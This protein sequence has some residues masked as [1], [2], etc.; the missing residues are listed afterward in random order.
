M[1]VDIDRKPIALVVPEAIAALRRFFDPAEDIVDERE[2]RRNGPEADG[3]RAAGI[4]VRSEPADELRGFV[5]HGHVRVSKAVDRLLSIADDED[6][7]GEGVGGSAQ[8][9]SP[10]PHELRDEL[11]LSPARV[12]EL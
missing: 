2:K 12:L 3:D 4:A 8:P 9:L 10:C 6:R 1:A 11:P 7:R 5:Q